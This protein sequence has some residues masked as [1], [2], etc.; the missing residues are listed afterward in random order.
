MTADPRKMIR[1]RYRSWMLDWENRLAFRATNRV[2][3][4]FDWGLEWTLD[5]PAA[6]R[7]PRN[8]HG[9]GEY[10]RDLNLAI[11]GSSE[12][13]FGYEPPR[14]FRLDGGLLKF[15]SP[16][17][18]PHAANDVAHARWFPAKGSKKA[19]VVLPHWNA[20]LNQHEGL[21]RGISRLGISALRISLPYHDYRMPPELERADYAVSSNVG[22]TMDAARQ[23][24]IDVRCCLDWLQSMGYERLGIVGTSLGSCYAF[25]ASAHDERLEVNVF[26][27]CSSYVADVVWTGLSTQHIKKG[28]EGEIDLDRL[29]ECWMA[30]SPVNYMDKFAAKRKKSKFI[31]TTYDTTFLPE[32]S[33][34]T[35][36]KVREYGIDHEVVV[37]PC[38]HYTMGESPFKFV[39][40]YHICSFLKKWL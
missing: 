16:V 33:E 35:I 39:D 6:A 27:H 5:W 34:Q 14:D 20:T 10:L 15:A 19:V 2:V 13:F 29:R 26:N 1:D 31:Y 3:R 36:G 23:A 30:I 28:L 9:P 24:V 11:V 37:L 4:P 18:T 17:E 38:G 8:G 21:C 40:G 12:E 25:L 22:R 32:F 7:L